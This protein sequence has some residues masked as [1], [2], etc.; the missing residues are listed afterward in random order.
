MQQK[1][2]RDYYTC[3]LIKGAIVR[4]TIFL[5]FL[6][7]EGKMQNEIFQFSYINN[8]LGPKLRAKLQN[9]VCFKSITTK[10]QIFVHL[11]I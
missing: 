10:M 9:L 1:L 11:K 5:R 4:S 7:L 2:K 8:C 6:Q 3:T